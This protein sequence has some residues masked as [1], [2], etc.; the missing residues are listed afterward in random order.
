MRCL[1]HTVLLL[2]FCLYSASASAAWPPPGLS[3]DDTVYVVPVEVE[4]VN[5]APPGITFTIH[6]TAYA[7][8]VY[9]K[10]PESGMWGALRESIPAGTET[11]TD[12]DVA[13]GTMYEYHFHAQAV[14]P[15]WD[16]TN[17]RTYVLAGIE[18][19][20]SGFRGRVVLVMPESIQVPLAPEIARFKRDL[21]GDGWTVHEVLTPDGRDEWSDAADGYHVQIRDEIRTIYNAHPDEVQHVVLL[22][23]VPQPRSG[24]RAAWAPDG[25]GDLG[26]VAA[27]MYYAD[28]DNTWTDTGTIT[29]AYGNNAGQVRP[30]WHNNPGDGRFDQSHF[31]HL[32]EAFEMGWGR[33]D[34]RGSVKGGNE[35]GALRDYLNKLHDYKHAQNGFVPGRRSIVRDAGSLYKHVQEEFWKTITPLSGME[36]LEYITGHDLPGSAGQPEAQYTFDHGPYLYFFMAGNEPN[37]P[38]DNSRA[39]FWT[40]FKSHVGYWDLNS[41]TRSRLA[42]P[43]SWTLSWTFAPPRGRYV[44]HRMALGGTMGDVM[45][46]TINNNHN[47]SGLYGSAVKQYIN[48]AWNVQNPSSGPGDYAGFTFHGHMGDPTLRDQ[49]IQSPQWVRGRV[50][51]GG[52]QVRVEW[53][54]SPD[55]IQGYDVYSA[56]DALGPFTKRNGSP[57]HINT[58]SGELNWTDTMPPSDPVVYMVRALKLESTPGGSY[59]NASVG[60]MAE[61]DR[62]P[63]PFEIQTNALPT[64]YLGTAYGFALQTAGGNPP[65]TWTIH[66][67]ALPTGLTLSPSGLLSGTPATGGSFPITLEAVDLLGTTLSVHLDMEVEMFSTWNLLPNGDFASPQHNTGAVNH[68]FSGNWQYPAAPNSQ[69]EYDADTQRASTSRDGREGAQPGLVY[70]VNDHQTR[71]G[72]VS[73][74]FD[75]VNTDGSGKPNTM[76]LRIYGIQGG[77]SWDHWNLGSNPVGDATLLHMDEITGSFDWTTFETPALPVDSGYEFY[78]L[79]FYPRDVTTSEGDFMAIDNLL[80]STSAPPPVNYVYNH[81]PVSTITSPANGSSFLFNTPISFSGTGSDVEDGEISGASWTSSIDGVF[82]PADGIYADLS[83]GEHVLTRAVT[84]SGGKSGSNTV[85]VTILGPIVLVAEADAYVRLSNDSAETNFG[86]NTVLRTRGSEN[87]E[88]LYRFDL[89]DIPGPVVSATL[90]LTLSASDT[91]L[92]TILELVDD[93]W[94]E[95]TVTYNTRPTYGDV[96]GTIETDGVSGKAQELDVSA[97]VEAQRNSGKVSFATTSGG[98][99]RMNSREVGTEANRPRLTVVYALEPESDPYTEWAAANGIPGHP[100]DEKDGVPNLLRY[101]LGGSSDTPASAFLLV[102]EV[103][104][105]GI[106]VN[107]TRIDDPSLTYEI[108]TTHT[109]MEW[110]ETPFWT[111]QGVGSGVVEVPTGDNQLYLY[112]K[113]RREK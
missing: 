80:W 103:G 89:S 43:N 4:S 84:D 55:A 53:P 11:W 31:R 88:T 44:Y 113:I 28:V 35:I 63:A 52:D 74:R 72:A 20:R 83:P 54:A 86:S 90:R 36:N 8:D 71:T 69:W 39:V 108:W 61:V 29:A 16:S 67:G 47:S 64:A 58:T 46:A 94:D 59:L 5:T 25:H 17:V 106:R 77:F 65:T 95:M 42:E 87:S 112:L 97:Y 24:L 73:F 96:I 100:T 9:R 14:P 1:I 41:W 79:R 91:G 2:H 57:L 22:G 7:L 104:D 75:L 93:S 105:F 37:Q 82:D 110:G 21:A 32:A 48:G 70:V 38:S 27:D 76:Y 66:S 68:W 30:A 13:V 26:A 33:I 102:P 34:F 3:G 51:N 10:H 92:L 60:R 98:F 56:P 78:V 40:G 19:D 45:K 111:G 101:A 6:N 81:P 107:F 85:T 99:V 12:T 109:L 50:L 15:S 62:S 49:M 18:V 23:R